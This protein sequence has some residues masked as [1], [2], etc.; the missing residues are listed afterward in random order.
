LRVGIFIFGAIM[1][2]GG[3]FPVMVFGSITD[4]MESLF[5]GWSAISPEYQESR[6]Y[7]IVGQ[8]MVVIGIII[9]IPGIILKKKESS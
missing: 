4:S 5:G 7:V 6:M 9:M 2:V 1:L 3:L 8:L